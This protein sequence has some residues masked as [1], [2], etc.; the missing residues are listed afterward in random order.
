[1]V[2]DASIGHSFTLLIKQLGLLLTFDTLIGH[3]FDC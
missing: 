2:F 1:M 3:N